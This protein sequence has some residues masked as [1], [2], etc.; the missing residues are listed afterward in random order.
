MPVTVTPCALIL[1]LI[2]FTV[3]LPFFCLC[4]VARIASRRRIPL[5]YNRP[6]L[7][8][9]PTFRVRCC[10]ICSVCMF[11]DFCVYVAVSGCFHMY[12]TLSS[13]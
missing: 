1:K 3:I 9:F 2:G 10:L 8:T 11:Y 13:S 4:C 7:R 6:G 12:S 5:F